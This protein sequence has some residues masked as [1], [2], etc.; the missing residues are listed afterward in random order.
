MN[1][2]QSEMRNEVGRRMGDLI[3]NGAKK[4]FSTSNDG[5]T[6]TDDAPTWEQMA[7]SLEDIRR[8]QTQKAR[9]LCRLMDLPAGEKAM[10]VVNSPDPDKQSVV[11]RTS[12]EMVSTLGGMIERLGNPS[13]I[14]V[15][16]VD[17]EEVGTCT[18]SSHFEEV[19][20]ES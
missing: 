8:N 7:Q 4:V 14:T 1:D 10:Y 2:I 13:G 5:L 9:A 15:Y 18:V 3:S 16:G 17:M 19:D 11:C 20:R 6:S 12:V